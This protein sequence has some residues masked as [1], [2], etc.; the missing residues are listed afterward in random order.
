MSK[1]LPKVADFMSVAE[2]VGIIGSP[3]STA[4]VCLEIMGH[5]V[6]RKLVGELVLFNYLQ[7]GAAQYALGQINE[8][9]MSNIWHESP[10]IRSL[11]RRRGGVDHVSA[12]QDTHQGKMLVSAVF[13]ETVAPNGAAVY[14]PSILGTVPATGTAVCLADDGILSTILR[15]YRRQLFYLGNV[16][17][18]K[19][20]MPL[21]FKHFDSGPDGAGEAYH[22]GVFER[23][24]R[25]SQFWRK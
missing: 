12:V 10:T 6:D 16:Y 4:E 3:S 17:G 15:P 5:S 25:E 23:P 13:E 19:P 2:H 9:R 24:A 1:N 21:W 22:L 7:D 8:V 18:S 11:A 20:K 14:D